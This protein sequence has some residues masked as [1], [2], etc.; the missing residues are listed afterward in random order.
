MYFENNLNYLIWF[1]GN[2]FFAVFTM[3]TIYSYWTT[4]W[5]E[6]YV[7]YFTYKDYL[8]SL[9]VEAPQRMAA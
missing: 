5:E 8:A 1:Y 3:L 6:N 9:E 7:D 4:W 2:A